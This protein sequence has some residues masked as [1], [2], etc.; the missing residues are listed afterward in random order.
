MIAINNSKTE[1]NSKIDIKKLKKSAIGNF[2]F[3]FILLGL[4][5]FLS[6][7]TIFYWEAWL[8]IISFLIPMI[9]MLR[10]LFKN[11][12]EL[13]LR[14][15]KRGETK[16]EQKV[17]KKLFNL[18]F[19]GIFVIPGFDKRFGWSN[20]YFVIVIL[21]DVIFILGYRFFFKVM[22][23]NSY[24]SRIIE[25]ETGEQKVITTGPYAIIRHPMYLAVLIIF[26]STPLAL[27][28]YWALLPVLPML[29]LLP[30]RIKGEEEFLLQELEGYA[31]YMQETKYR[32]IPRVW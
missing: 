10:Y 24:A 22:K 16:S 25:V 19:L 4:L 30:I 15:L 26:V 2:S 3:L 31:E 20:V 5:F 18:I 29:V 12:P 8:Y 27:G 32:L 28:S 9:L 7:G 6:A 14:R 13:L 23:E 1:E 11:D 17:V 21:A